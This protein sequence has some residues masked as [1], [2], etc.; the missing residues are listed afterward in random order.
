M[1]C[2]L[3]GLQTVALVAVAALGAG[4][5]T[6]GARTITW[7][8]HQ[9]L[10]SDLVEHD[11][12]GDSTISYEADFTWRATFSVRGGRLMP[13][14]S[15]GSVHGTSTRVNDGVTACSGPVTANAV[16]TPAMSADANGN[17]RFEAAAIPGWAGGGEVMTCYDFYPS[18]VLPP[19]PR[20]AFAFSAKAKLSSLLH[21]TA[22]ASDSGGGTWSKNHPPATPGT[23]PYTTR[24]SLS[25]SASV[26]G[27][28][29][30]CS[31]P[32]KASAALEGGVCTYE[33]I[34][35][36][37]TK[38]T[39]N[40]P[41]DHRAVIVAADPIVSEVIDPPT[42]T[43]IIADLRKQSA[44]CDAKG[45]HYRA[46]SFAIDDPL[47][48]GKMGDIT[49]R[50][51]GNKPPVGKSRIFGT[52]VGQ[53]VRLTRFIGFD[54]RPILNATGNSETETFDILCP[55]YRVIAPN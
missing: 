14:S 31:A 29:D 24:A 23:P 43:R 49:P 37:C 54:G 45:S 39:G 7:T 40:R 33:W 1:S 34:G 2:R 26:S 42:G 3:R 35:A 11:V 51:P 21:G 20:K 46:V 16:G 8:G 19:I 27:R 9:T 22:S 12:S 44:A 25:W 4:A 41:T 52:T 5:G 32:G 28:P 50:E 17:V 10:R 30:T 55:L 47:Q 36:V 6:A 15:R 18:P 38:G 53:N 13:S 48:E